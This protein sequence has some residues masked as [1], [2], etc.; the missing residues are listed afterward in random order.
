[1]LGGRRPPVGAAGPGGRARVRSR[2]TRRTRSRRGCSSRSGAT[3]T[4]TRS[5]ARRCTSASRLKNWNSS[6]TAR[7]PGGSCSRISTPGTT[8]GRAGLRA[9]RIPRPHA[10]SRGRV[11]AVHAVQLSRAE[12]E[13]LAA[14]RVTV[15][16]CPRSNRH[17]GVG[18]PPVEA[19]YEAGLAVAVGTDSRASAPDLVRLARARS[20]APPRP[21]RARREA[22]RERDTHRRRVTGLRRANSGRS[23]PASVRRSSPSPS[24]QASTGR[25]PVQECLVSGI[26]PEGVRWAGDVG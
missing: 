10:I 15:V 4:A 13:R 7:G 16:T 23:R 24:L 26:D 1:M 6:S 11:L 12:L 20:D 18:D 21:R 14:R 5:P 19:F 22:P 8:R 25:A 9:R 17:V 2:R 3:S